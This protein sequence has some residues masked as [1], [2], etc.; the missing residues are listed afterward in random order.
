MTVC[1]DDCYSLVHWPLTFSGVV[2]ILSLKGRQEQC[3]FTTRLRGLKLDR[4]REASY[5]CAR[6]DSISLAC[7]ACAN[8]STRY[9]S[10]PTGRL[11]ERSTCLLPPPIT[12][13]KRR[14]M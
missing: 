11:K 12:S 6:Q 4:A 2:C 1:K 14:I 8:S 10:A 5:A 13:D 3:P 9:R 7:R